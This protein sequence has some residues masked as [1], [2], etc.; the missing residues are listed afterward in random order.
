LDDVFEDE[1]A[2]DAHGGVIA[3]GHGTCCPNARAKVNLTFHLG[4]RRIPPG[5]DRGL[6]LGDEEDE[7]EDD[8][9]NFL[10]NTGEPPVVE[11]N[12]VSRC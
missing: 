12:H 6:K 9:E 10:P 5:F 2:F 11:N 3:S 1:L 8:F 7:D 4:L